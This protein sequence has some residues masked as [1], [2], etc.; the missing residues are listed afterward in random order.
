MRVTTRVRPTPVRRAL[1]SVGLA[2][3]IAGLSA[4][5]EGSSV[6]FK[7]S[8]ISGTKIGSGWALT[9]M[10]GKSYTSSNFAGK[11]QLVFFGFTQCPD[12]CPTAL[13]E[14]SEMM[15]TLG[16]QASR[17]QVL[18]IT[19]DPERDSPEVLRAYVSGFNTSFLGLTGTPAQ[20]KQ[21]AASFKAYY[22]KAPAA[23]G[24][25]SMDHSSSF[26]LLDPKGDARVLVSNTA[27][28]AALAHDIKLL[29]K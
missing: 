12:I 14:L 24:G 25:Y 27:G 28:T 11:V 20:I 26:Y 9:G 13:A 19:V 6:K 29:L 4:C 16:D 23:K 5:G 10:D 22:A 17:V 21:V 1:L 3:L 8:D 2:A 18:M 7:G 15:R